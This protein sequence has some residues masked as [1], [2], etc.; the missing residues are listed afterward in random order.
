MGVGSTRHGEWEEAPGPGS[1]VNSGEAGGWAS[2]FEHVPWLEAR[3]R[4][5]MA[6][7]ERGILDDGTALKEAGPSSRSAKHE[8]DQFGFGWTIRD[9]RG[10]FMGP[11]CL[12]ER[13]DIVI[14]STSWSSTTSL[15]DLIME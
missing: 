6:T 11:D 12:R 15:W 9:I 7:I 10:A 14:P 13:R 3:Q 5:K 4:Y 1:Q 8:S 2:E